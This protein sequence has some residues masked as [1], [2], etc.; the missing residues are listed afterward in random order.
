MTV[1]DAEQFLKEKFDFI[2]INSLEG[3]PSALAWLP[4][5]SEIWTTYGSKMDCPWKLCWGRR[6]S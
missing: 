5:K 1:L 6:K 2:K 4:E 3:C